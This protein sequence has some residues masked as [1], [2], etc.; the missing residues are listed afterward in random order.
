M[1]NDAVSV[2][3]VRDF[4][5][6]CKLDIPNFENVAASV[7]QTISVLIRFSRRSTVNVAYETVSELGVE[8][9]VTC[10]DRRQRRTWNGAARSR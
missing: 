5:D 10:G 6:M 4:G 7:T 2:L 9:G 3:I 1:L 8:M